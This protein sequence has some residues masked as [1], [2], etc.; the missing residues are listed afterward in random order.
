MFANE[1][2]PVR[3]SLLNLVLQDDIPDLLQA[4]SE[5][6]SVTLFIK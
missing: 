2:G 5:N 4:M 6:V 1:C 3:Q